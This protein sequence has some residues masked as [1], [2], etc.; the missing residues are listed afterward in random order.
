MV[1][2]A[3]SACIFRRLRPAALPQANIDRA[4]LA[5]GAFASTSGRGNLRDIGRNEAPENLSAEHAASPHSSGV[6]PRLVGMARRPHFGN[7]FSA[8]GAYHHSLGQRP[9]NC[10]ICETVALAAR[11]KADEIGVR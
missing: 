1:S 7:F 4:P 8:E 10:G 5:L 2:R 3:F 6:V 9:R 11:F